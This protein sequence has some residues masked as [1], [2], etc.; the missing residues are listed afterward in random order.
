MFQHR[1]HPLCELPSTNVTNFPPTT[2]TCALVGTYILHIVCCHT[3]A[4]GVI[5][6]Q[7]NEGLFFGNYYIA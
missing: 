3:K 6:T 5:K 4:Y 7:I 2:P 1:S